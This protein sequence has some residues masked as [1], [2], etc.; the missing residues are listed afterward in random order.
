MQDK[1]INEDQISNPI[2]VPLHYKKYM[3]EERKIIVT[4]L[5]RILTVPS[6]SYDGPED[7]K[8]IDLA[9]PG[10][11]PKLVYIATS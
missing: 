9:S 5:E 8:K 4:K 10:E 11:E 2:S 1:T 7:T 3:I 6:I